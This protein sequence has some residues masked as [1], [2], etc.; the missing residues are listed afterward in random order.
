MDF[1][2]TCFSTTVGELPSSFKESLSYYEAI[3]FL[4]KRIDGL[5]TLFNTIVNGELSKYISEH[6][7]ELMFDA[8][9]DDAAE[10]LI[11]SIN[12]E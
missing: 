4:V 12:E 1:C 5:E 9:Y 11:L 2:N 3:C 8:M 6:F 10:K 7:N